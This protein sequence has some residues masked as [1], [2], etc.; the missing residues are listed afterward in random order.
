M[1]NEF[2]ERKGKENTWVKGVFRQ[3]QI[4]NYPFE[5]NSE[6]FGTLTKIPIPKFRN[7]FFL[8]RFQNFENLINF[9]IKKFR[10]FSKL[11]RNFWNRNLLEIFLEF[12]VCDDCH[13]CLSI[14]KSTYHSLSSF[15]IDV[16]RSWVSEYFGK[17]SECFQKI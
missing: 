14:Y 17:L 7:L 3:E 9:G 10:K 15:F 1:V 12:S 6:I 13:T 4:G 8:F 16:R 5:K 2:T 11:F